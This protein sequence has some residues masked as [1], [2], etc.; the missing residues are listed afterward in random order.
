VW[1]KEAI[2]TPTIFKLEAILSRFYEVHH[3]DH[4]KGYS[5]ACDSIVELFKEIIPEYKELPYLSTDF[6]FAV[7]YDGFNECRQAMLE[8]IGK[9][10]K[11]REKGL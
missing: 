6:K 11:E 1:E 10:S 4:E 5:E 7:R 2:L 3:A 8:A 9:L